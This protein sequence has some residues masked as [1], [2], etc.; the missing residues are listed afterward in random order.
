M[1]A[2]SKLHELY[3]HTLNRIEPLS[4]ELGRRLGN[5]IR[6]TATR[7][8]V[9]DMSDTFSDGWIIGN[10]K[11]EEIS[12]LKKRIAELEEAKLPKVKMIKGR[13]KRLIDI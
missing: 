11:D 3:G 13:P 5:V 8:N 2:E 9:E 4:S 1:A 6:G 7:V 10:S 12:E